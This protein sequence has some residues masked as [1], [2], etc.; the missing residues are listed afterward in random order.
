M[1]TIYKSPIQI[2]DYG[3]KTDDELRKWVGLP[4]IQPPR[5]ARPPCCFW[6]I[7]SGSGWPLEI[8]PDLPTAFENWVLYADLSAVKIVPVNISLGSAKKY[9]PAAD[10][11][12]AK[13]LERKPNDQ[14]I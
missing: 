1:R 4:P 14:G 5:L 6:L 12:C 3:K 11:L 9:Q 10:E 2:T 8:Y 13:W 7:V